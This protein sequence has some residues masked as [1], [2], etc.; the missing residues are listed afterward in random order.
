LWEESTCLCFSR[1]L[2]WCP[3]LHTSTDPVVRQSGNCNTIHL[4]DPQGGVQ[5]SSFPRIFGLLV[6]A[7]LVN[8]NEF[9]T[10]I[11]STL[12]H[13]SSTNLLH[14]CDFAMDTLRPIYLCEFPIRI[15]CS[16]SVRCGNCSRGSNKASTSAPQGGKASTALTGRAWEYAAL[17][18]GVARRL[19]RSQVGARN[20]PDARA[21]MHQRPF[22]GT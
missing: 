10:H 3:T 1:S 17:K 19:L 15:A 4:A 8:N 11:W 2:C 6:H 9:S 13:K 21:R 18:E 7:Y 20:R 16:S 12:A 14:P 22:R 5:S